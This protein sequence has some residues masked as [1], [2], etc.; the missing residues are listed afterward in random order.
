MPLMREV[1]I[2][3]AGVKRMARSGTERRLAEPKKRCRAASLSGTAGFAN[4]RRCAL[5]R[6]GPDT[7]NPFSWKKTGFGIVEERSERR[8][9]GRLHGV[10]LDGVVAQ[11]LKC[12]TGWG[13]RK[14]G[15]V[16]GRPIRVRKIRDARPSVSNGGRWRDAPHASV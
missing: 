7:R 10:G 2:E 16:Q 15:M 14:D 4:C 13:E 11:A 5:V 12:V 6:A 8:R 1:G 9:D 3:N